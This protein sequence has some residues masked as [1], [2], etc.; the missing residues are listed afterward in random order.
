MNM[1]IASLSPS[2]ASAYNEQYSDD[3]TEWR[4]LGGKY[5]ADNILAMSGSHRFQ[6]VLDCGAGEGSVLKYLDLSDAFSEL[7]A[8]EISDSAIEQIRKRNLSKLQEVLRFNGYEIPY[9]EQY[10]DMAYCSHVI[11]HVEHPRILLRELKRV[12]GYQVF[13]IPLDYS[14]N[15]DQKVNHFLSYGHINIYTP[16]LFRFLL[17][18]EGFSILTERL[19]HTA[20]EIVRYN[21]YKNMKIKNNVKREVSLRLRS[22][23]KLAKRILLGQ[24]KYREYG[25]SSYTCLT[26]SDG[27]FKIF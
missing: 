15:V 25:F 6:K 20:P 23:K 26:S 19:T 27:K 10:F 14:V 1:K 4:E 12:S 3:M 24:Q 5:K 21:W 8:I 18:S 7:Y 2:L 13:E 22:I 11:E 16:S 9:P 17:R